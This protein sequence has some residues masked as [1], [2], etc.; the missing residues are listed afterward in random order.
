MLWICLSFPDL[1]LAVFARA[2]ARRSPAVTAS[3][4]HRPDVIVANV[5]ARKR[6]VVAGLSIA[7]ALALDPDLVVHLRDERAEAA[8]LERIALWAGQWTPA[9]SIELPGCVLLEVAGVLRYFEGLER[10]AQRIRAGL[11]EMGFESA[12]AV[13][14]TAGAASLL[15]RAGCAV[16]IDASSL[17]RALAPLP[18]DLLRHARSSIATLQA[19]GVESIGELLALPR[20]GVARRFGQALLDEVDRALGKLP[21]A[22][23][24]FTAPER[25]EGQLELPAP[26][27]EAEALLFGARRLVVELCGFLHARG[28][29]VT[30][31]ACDLVHR[32]TAPTSIGL[33]LRSTRQVEHIM[34]VLRE[35]LARETLPDRVAAIRLATEEIAPLAGR[36]G[37]FFAAGASS[38]AGAQLVE[39]LRARLGEDAVRSL[40]LQA[41]HRPER[42]WRWEPA[43]NASGA[44]TGLRQRG[45]ASRPAPVRPLWLLPEP[46]A[47]A[48]GPAEASVQLE[49]G[50]ERIESGWWDGHDAARDYFVGRNERGEALWLY[51]D[52]GGRWFVHGVFA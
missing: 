15:A 14:P 2:D 48:A 7:A 1:P 52:R 21:E 19:V 25:Y 23:A 45:D 47:L 46:H 50:P 6:G 18:V 12:I 17:A 11:D 36:D 28:A 41:D 20:D 24:P 10:L 30:R 3:A 4:S 32:D 40:A 9:V 39:R 16:E 37:D 35:R 44:A 13:A 29:G 27:E 22:R 26:V 8:A 51:R 49:S 43:L 5:A 38:E 34:T 42:A 31:L 33:G